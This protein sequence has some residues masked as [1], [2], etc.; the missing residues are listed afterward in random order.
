MNNLSNPEHQYIEHIFIKT[1]VIDD[2]ENVTLFGYL[3]GNDITDLI[4]YDFVCKFNILT[5]LLLLGEK[6]GDQII[7]LVSDTLTKELEIPTIIDLKEIY[8]RILY[9]EDIKLQVFAP[10]EKDEN[11]VWIPCTD[12][13]YYIESLQSKE[14][15]E[16][17]DI[18]LVPITDIYKA[19]LK[20]YAV[21]LYRAYRYYK[22]LSVKKKSKKLARKRAGLSDKLLFKMAKLHYKIYTAKDENNFE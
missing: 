4:P 10:D 12:N 2:T 19:E 6:F 11:E 20:K 17:N 9:V 1:I 21:T 3:S 8:G 13:C 18:K 15:T 22:Q 7:E 14:H 5:D 16:H